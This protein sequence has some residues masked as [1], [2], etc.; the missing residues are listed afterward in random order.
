MTRDEI[1]QHN[2]EQDEKLQDWMRGGQPGGLA[3][4]YYQVPPKEPQRLYWTKK[5][6]AH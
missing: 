6:T 2:A 5:E 1:I 4:V 3:L